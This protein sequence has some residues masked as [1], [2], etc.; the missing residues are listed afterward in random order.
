MN[1]HAFTNKIKGQMGE[2]RQSLIFIG[3]LALVSGVSFYLG[4]TARAETAKA[5]PVVI[6]CPLEA[7]MSSESL[8]KGVE[9]ANF[10]PKSSINSVTNVDAPNVTYVA[11]KNG[12]KYYPVGC[13]GADRIKNENKVYFHTE[14]GALSAGYT[15][16]ATCQ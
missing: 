5:S 4:Y 11:S 6:N 3:V 16:S 9:N 13:S 7:Y 2:R 8:S 12:S 1:I 15:L 10:T 14:T